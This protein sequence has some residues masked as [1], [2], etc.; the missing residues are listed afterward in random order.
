MR[1]PPESNKHAPPRTLQS[2]EAASG[3]PGED[4]RGPTTE[5]G[6]EHDHGDRRDHGE[7]EDD[8]G[9]QGAD[10]GAAQTAATRHAAEA[11]GRGPAGS[12]ADPDHRRHQDHPGLWRDGPEGSHYCYTAVLSAASTEDH[13]HHL[14]QLKVTGQCLQRMNIY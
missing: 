14:R 13:A 12:R 8:G 3:P 7:R 2:R 10:G 11:A 1:S 5:G 9:A 4:R 6:G